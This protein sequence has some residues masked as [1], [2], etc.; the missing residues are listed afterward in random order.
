MRECYTSKVFSKPPC[1][2]AKIK[3]EKSVQL[4]AQTLRHVKFLPNNRSLFASEYTSNFA[5]FSLSLVRFD[6]QLGWT[7][8]KTHNFEAPGATTMNFTFL[9]ISNLPRGRQLS[10]IFKKICSKQKERNVAPF[11]VYLTR[12]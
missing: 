5:T 8:L 7:F 12:K 1:L 6:S 4:E 11:G 9:E 10:L 3:L 2:I